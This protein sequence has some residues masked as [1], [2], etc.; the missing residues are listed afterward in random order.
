MDTLCT[1]GEDVAVR[2]MTLSRLT[3]TAGSA[4]QPGKFTVKVVVDGTNATCAYTGYTLK[5]S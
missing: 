4:N 2:L 5:A 3:G 1:N